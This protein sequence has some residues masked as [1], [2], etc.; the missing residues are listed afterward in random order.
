VRAD[1]SD[2]WAHPWVSGVD[3]MHAR[4]VR[5]AFGRHSHDSF[6][7]GVLE[8]GQEDLRIGDRQH[9]LGRGAL[10]L[11]NPGVV[12]NGRAADQDGWTYRVLYPDVATVRAAA[13]SGPAWFGADVVDDPQA[14]ALVVA[15]HR[16]GAGDDPL[17]SST[18][19]ARALRL[20]LHRHGDREPAPTRP[21]GVT[22]AERAR[23]LL[24]D[25]L[26]TPPTLDEL[27][28]AVGVGKFALLR[29]FRD[30][31]GLPPHT[32]LN[33]L[34]VRRA[35]QLL[36]DGVGAAHVAAQV[37]F[38]DQSH[39]TRQFR[40]IVGVPPGHYQRKNVQASRRHRG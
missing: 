18:L 27:A 11:L 17:T 20:V 19:L 23:E 9:R 10:V 26:V 33:V 40:R 32:Y 24:H 13:E 15:A 3:L 2:Y 39:L 25:Q 37:G 5:H 31:F 36:D 14:A 22:A 1:S 28:A 8:S 35:R 4:F 16:A 21:A 38:F 30:R 7:L 34:R 12:H 6:V 29:S